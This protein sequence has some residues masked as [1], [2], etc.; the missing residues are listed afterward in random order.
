MQAIPKIDS[1]LLSD[2]A[3]IARGLLSDL[4]PEQKEEN[5]SIGLATR[6]QNPLHFQGEERRRLR[7]SPE[8]TKRGCCQ[9][10]QHPDT[11]I[12]REDFKSQYFRQREE[13]VG[14]H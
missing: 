5:S 4:R 11:R 1:M 3:W 6:R 13:G 7:P 10:E 12:K 2:I 8:D 9:R 14:T